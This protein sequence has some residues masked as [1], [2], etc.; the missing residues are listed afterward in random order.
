MIISRLQRITI[1][2]TF[3]KYM[4]VNTVFLVCFLKSRQFV[5]GGAIIYSFKFRFLSLL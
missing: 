1:D 3:A 2:E 4:D 5:L